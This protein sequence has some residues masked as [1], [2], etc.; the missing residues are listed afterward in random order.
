MLRDNLI[1]LDEE[2]VSQDSVTLEGPHDVKFEFDEYATDQSF[3][4]HEDLQLD[5]VKKVDTMVLP[6]V[7]MVQHKI[8]PIPHIDFVI[9]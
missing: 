3:I 4:M 7:H 5:E 8:V 6:M 9:P 1:K 2:K